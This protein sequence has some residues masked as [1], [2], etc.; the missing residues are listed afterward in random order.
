MMQFLMRSEQPVKCSIF[1]PLPP[2]PPPW[3]TF[4]L[5]KFDGTP[6]NYHVSS[7]SS[8][9]KYMITSC[10]ITRGSSCAALTSSSRIINTPPSPLFLYRILIKTRGKLFQTFS[11]NFVLKKKRKKRELRASVS[12]LATWNEK[13]R[14]E[15]DGERRTTHANQSV[16]QSVSHSV[17]PFL[18]AI[19]AI[20]FRRSTANTSFVL[21]C[22]R[23]TR[24]ISISGCCSL[25]ARY[26]PLTFKSIG[27]R[28]AAAQ[29]TLPPRY[30]ERK[31]SFASS[32]NRISFLFL[33]VFI[34]ILREKFQ[35]SWKKVYAFPITYLIRMSRGYSRV[36]AII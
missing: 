36:R 34:I 26:A 25:S 32:K 30:I 5:C 33:S 17:L 7:L 2:S 6:P 21:H 18:A 9:S 12:Y 11:K 24:Q 10:F 27:Y 3:Q 8:R 29:R 13:R 35:V 14:K 31:N 1:R 28:V 4:K 19:V 23:A 20:V 15:W 22:P 16:S